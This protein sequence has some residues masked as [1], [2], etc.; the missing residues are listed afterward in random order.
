MLLLAF[1][2]LL[3]FV[4]YK[5]GQLSHSNLPFKISSIIGIYGV[6]DIII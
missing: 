2:F 1:I 4:S 6:N 5:S 3:W